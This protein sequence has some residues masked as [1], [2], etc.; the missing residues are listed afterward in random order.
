ML[1]K[2]VF[3]RVEDRMR[4]ER[5]L[6]EVGFYEYSTSSCPLLDEIY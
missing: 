1:Q 2:A 3:A 5:G 6:L 4:M